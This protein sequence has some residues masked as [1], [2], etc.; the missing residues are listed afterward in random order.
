[1]VLRKTTHKLEVKDDGSVELEIQY[2][3]SGAGLLAHDRCTNILLS[4]PLIELNN[5]YEIMKDQL[6]KC[7]SGDVRD[8]AY[9]D[10]NKA[11]AD[12]K[13]TLLKA[14]VLRIISLLDGEN[15]FPEGVGHV[16]TPNATADVSD[17]DAQAHV[18]VYRTIE[19]QNN[20]S[21]SNPYTTDR[22]IHS[23]GLPIAAWK[24]IQTA[25]A[26][27]RNSAKI[28]AIHHRRT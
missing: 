3:A 2:I 5:D 24:E 10:L 18:G 9:K 6:S 13:E 7:P 15:K 26:P 27:D 12:L 21:R 22:K 23:I 19:D 16:S 11:Y 20:G 17:R 8:N 25:G 4:E 1:M 14:Q 28:N